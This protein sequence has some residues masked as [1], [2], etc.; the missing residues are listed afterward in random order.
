MTVSFEEMRLEH[1]SQVEEIEVV[2]FP[3][4]WSHKAFAYEITQNSFA[5]YIVAVAGGEVIGYGG[6]WFI[7]DE[8]HITNVAVRRDWRMKGVGRALMLEILRRAILMGINSMTLEVRPSNTA[9]RNLYTSLGFI[10]KGRRKRYYT[11]TN[12]DAIIM[13]K[14]GLL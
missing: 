14:E 3:T 13:W 1:L 12:E 6:M 5:H 4:P 8:A 10:E 11:D 7:L 2:S 9:A